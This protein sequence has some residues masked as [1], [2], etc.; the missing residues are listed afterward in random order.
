MSESSDLLPFCKCGCGLRVTK[1]RNKW[2]KGHYGRKTP[3]A[4]IPEPQLCEC[5]CGKLALPGN[6]FIHEHQ[7]RGKEISDEARKN[8]SESQKEYHK[9]NP[10]AGSDHSKKLTQYYVDNTE[11]REAAR[12]K[13]IEQFATQKSRDAV[14]KKAIEVWGNPEFR[15][16][17][18]DIA[19]ERCADS[20]VRRR[21]S[22][23]EIQYYIDNPE[24]RNKMSEIAKNSDNVKAAHKK[25]IGGNDLVWHH[26]AYDF[27][28]PDALRVRIT[29]SFHSSIHHPP[30]I[31]FSV[32][33]YSLID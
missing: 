7:R 23:I 15:K 11:A 27:G 16:R 12:L 28:R 1:L 6:R 21:M 31:Q 17:M 4:P 32:H 13:S 18:S 5:G 24:A 33:G 8:M 29:R 9:N 22:D 10:N 20:E 26:V 30:G 3:W 2:I 14:S 25:Q 19:I